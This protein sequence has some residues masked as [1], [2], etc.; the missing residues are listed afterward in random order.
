MADYISESGYT[1]TDEE[2]NSAAS[3]QGKTFDDII[4]KNK[5]K[6][7]TDA[8][9]KSPGK[10][11]PTIEQDA[12]VAG[13]KNTASKSAKSS[14][15]SSNNPFG[16]VNIFDPLNI[17]KNALDAAQAK[18][19]KEVKFDPKKFAKDMSANK[20]DGFYTKGENFEKLTGVKQKKEEEKIANEVFDTFDSFNYSKLSP[21]QKLLLD[22]Q[23]ADLLQSNIKP[24]D[25]YSL[26][27]KEI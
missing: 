4:K 2:I 5:L 19:A 27:S 18:P 23:A 7:K 13:T 20:A 26:S 6:L 16:K 24:G 3:E 12:T 1:Y 11:M 15:A 22:D 8:K 21:E 17:T 14:S 9:A 10:K 25:P